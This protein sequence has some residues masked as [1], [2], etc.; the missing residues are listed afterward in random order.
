MFLLEWTTDDG[1]KGFNTYLTGSP[2]YDLATYKTWFSKIEA[3]KAI[4][5]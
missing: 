4:L 1:E 2:A 3:K 5:G